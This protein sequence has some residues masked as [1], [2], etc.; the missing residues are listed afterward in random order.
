M[1]I[2][3]IISSYVSIS[4][5]KLGSKTYGH[6]NFRDDFV[7]ALSPMTTEPLKIKIKIKRRMNEWKEHATL[8]YDDLKE[9]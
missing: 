6:E 9:A 4:T 5:P 8:K 1:P 3:D 7:K 2:V